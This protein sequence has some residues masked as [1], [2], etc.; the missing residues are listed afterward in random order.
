MKYAVIIALVSTLFS[1]AVQEPY[2]N[3]I[4]DEFSLDS[5]EKLSKVQFF[6]SSTIVLDEEIKNEN[7]T[8]TSNGT[9][10]YSSITKKESVIIQ[11][12]TPCVFDSYGTK[13]ELLVRFETGEGKVLSFNTKNEST[14]RYYFNVDWNQAG[15]PRIEYGGVTYKI[16][17]MRGSPRSAHIKVAKK[18]LEKVKRKDRFVRGMKVK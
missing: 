7:S 6:L 18:K 8:T 11:A 9:L 3:K 10:I 17:V 2:T 4:R 13:D 1:C 15:G 12:G 16:D 5:E 14:S